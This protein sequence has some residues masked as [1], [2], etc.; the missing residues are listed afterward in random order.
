MGA[1]Q[2]PEKRPQSRA[3][4]AEPCLTSERVKERSLVTGQ[5][6]F[7]RQGNTRAT[8]LAE[9]IEEA[10]WAN[11][12]DRPGLNFA[13]RGTVKTE[14]IGRREFVINIRLP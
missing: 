10:K 13:L 1:G 7:L 3:Q 6:C 5:E 4:A 12:A 14:A 2:E 11:S 9:K 8:E